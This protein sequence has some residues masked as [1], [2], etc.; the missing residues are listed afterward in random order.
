MK[1][2][3]LLS[4]TALKNFRQLSFILVLILLLHLVFID[5]SFAATATPSA[6]ESPSPSASASGS[7][8]AQKINELKEKAAS[9]AAD[10]ISQVTKKLQNKAYFG[11]ISSIDGSSIKVVFENKDFTISTNEYTGY[12]S[13]IKSSKKITGIKDFAK[14]DFISALGDTDDKGVLNAKK[15]I[16]S[17]PI[18]TESS[19]LVW[20][21]VQ[22]V[23][24]PTITVKMSNNT[25]Q[26]VTSA[27]KGLIFLGQ[28]EASLNDIKVGRTIIAR[29]KISANSGH[30]SNYI[31]IIPP[32]AGAKPEKVV[33]SSKSA[34]ISSASPSSSPKKP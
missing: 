1:T 9:K 19:Q 17:T 18:G 33:E 8:L 28:E 23:S 13:K 31:Y 25:D 14:G 2:N 12:S 24:G 26:I 3:F 22:K 21:V 20:G 7:L 30:F 5:N 32:S 15:I 16:K 11:V 34:V 10:F 27:V 4:K 29:G 6:K